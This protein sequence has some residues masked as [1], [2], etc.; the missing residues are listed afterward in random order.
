[1]DTNYPSNS[2]YIDG[3][4][5]VPRERKIESVIDS[6]PKTRKHNS[7]LLGVIFAQDLKDIKESLW[8]DYIEPKIKDVVYSSLD[9]VF[10]TA[11]SAFEMMIF[12]EA[13][14][15]RKKN[16]DRA[17]YTSY[18]SYS[19]SKPS[20][21]FGYSSSRNYNLDDVVYPSRGDAEVVLSNL[22]DDLREY[23]TV[24]VAAFYRYSN[25]P[26][27]STDNNYGWQMDADEFEDKV[28]VVHVRDGFILDL[29]RPKPIN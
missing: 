15:N 13:R 18:S 16:E 3:K 8:K 14:K 17:S 12:G 5:D 29:P 1:M 27:R 6:T 7:G 26:P 2:R 19:S 28:S 9:G 25:V 10:E 23:H 20:M 11:R 21:S 4:P 24:S 22:I